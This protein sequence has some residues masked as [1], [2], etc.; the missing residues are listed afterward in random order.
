MFSILAM[1]DVDNLVQRWA[2]LY[3]D[4]TESVEGGI[5]L[6]MTTPRSFQ[7]EKFAITNNLS[8]GVLSGSPIYIA[9]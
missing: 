2:E 7:W 6:R 4:S 9:S 8:Y 3:A 1:T 5:I